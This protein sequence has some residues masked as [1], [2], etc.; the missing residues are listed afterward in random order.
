MADESVRQNR[1]VYS[2]GVGLKEGFAFTPGS[3]TTTN[4]DRD[5][6]LLIKHESLHMWQSR[7]FGPLFQVGTLAYM[8]GGLPVGFV[9]AGLTGQ[10]VI[11]G[12]LAAGYASSPFERVAYGNQNMWPPGKP[13]PKGLLVW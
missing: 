8:A 6:E 3:N 4:W 1:M 2:G 9:G 13:F 12:A 11:D 10:N 7:L 5:A